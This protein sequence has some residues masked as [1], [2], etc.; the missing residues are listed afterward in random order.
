VHKGAPTLVASPAGEV[1]V[2][3]SGS[4]ALAKGGT[5]DVLTG[6]IASFLAQALAA[7]EPPAEA[8]LDAACVAC[9]LHGRTGEIEARERGERGVIASDLFLSLGKA[10]V[11]LE[12]LD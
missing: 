6:F 7:G 9:Y 11:E 2:N 4:S 1:W 10:M 12:S 5:G 8:A 3:G